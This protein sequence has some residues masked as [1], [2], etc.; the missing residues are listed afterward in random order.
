MGI[1]EDI[2]LPDDVVAVF[3]LPLEVKH[4]LS[5][6]GI[7]QAN[8]GSGLVVGDNDGLLVIVRPRVFAEPT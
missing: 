1:S 3:R 7:L 5:L 4:L 6:T 8:Y 2:E